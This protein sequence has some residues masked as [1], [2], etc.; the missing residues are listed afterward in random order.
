MILLNCTILLPLYKTG[1]TAE[2][3]NN[4]H[5]ANNTGVIVLSPIQEFSLGNAINEPNRTYPS[6]ALS[7]VN[8]CLVFGFILLF[9]KKVDFVV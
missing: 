9:K 8:V 1:S 2:N 3:C 5:T 7:V 6:L 4:L